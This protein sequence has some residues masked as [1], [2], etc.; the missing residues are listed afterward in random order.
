VRLG[1][2][3]NQERRRRSRRA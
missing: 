2:S 3:T 1:S